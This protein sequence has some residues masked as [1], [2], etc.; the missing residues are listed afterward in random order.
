MGVFNNYFRD[1]ER[2][3][4]IVLLRDLTVS[5]TWKK[6]E[7]HFLQF[8]LNELVIFLDWGTEQN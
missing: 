4:C 1:P 7:S 2:H 5:P 8:F 6:T 3:E